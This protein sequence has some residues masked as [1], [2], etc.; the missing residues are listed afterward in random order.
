M[1]CDLPSA[2]S[3]QIT[4]LNAGQPVVVTSYA[5]PDVYATSFLFMVYDS[6]CYECS[7]TSKEC[8]ELPSQDGVRTALIDGHPHIYVS[9]YMY[10]GMS[11]YCYGMHSVRV[12]V[13]S[14]VTN[15]FYDRV[16]FC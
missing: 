5:T 9:F 15:H 6:A 3:Y 11:R 12:V 13:I 2:G 7:L 8:T 10:T 14:V 4:L 16:C 1:A